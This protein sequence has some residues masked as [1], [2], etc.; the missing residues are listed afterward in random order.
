M[1]VQPDFWYEKLCYYK[2]MLDFDYNDTFNMCCILR[3]W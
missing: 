1:F 3:T 2:A